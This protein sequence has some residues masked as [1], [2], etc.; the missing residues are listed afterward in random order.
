M[1]IGFF[2]KIVYHKMYVLSMISMLFFILFIG[3]KNLYRKLHLNVK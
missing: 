1:T 2:M 3:R